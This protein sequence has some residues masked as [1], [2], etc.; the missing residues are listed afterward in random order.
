M[1][2]E[3]NHILTIL[4]KKKQK[5]MSPREHKKIDDATISPTIETIS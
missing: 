2:L 4:I 1:V 5:F 3:H